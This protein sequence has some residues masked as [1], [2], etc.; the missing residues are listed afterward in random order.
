ME[1]VEAK[2]NSSIEKIVQLIFNCCYSNAVMEELPDTEMKKLADELRLYFESDYCA[3]GKFDGNFVEDRIISYKNE[4]KVQER[5]LKDVIRVSINNKENFVCQAI[6][7]SDDVLY[8]ENEELK[9]DPQYKTYENTILKGPLNNTTI[10]PIRNEQ[11]EVQGYVQ[12]INSKRK[13][14]LDDIKPFY[15]H[16]LKLIIIIKRTDVVKDTISFKKDYE[17]ITDLQSKISNVDELLKN[18]MEYFSREFSAGIISYRIPL[19]VGLERKP[20]FFLRECYISEKVS[21]Y[22]SKE[23]FFKERLVIDEKRMSSYDKLKC[24]D[25]NSIIINKTQDPDYYQR[26]SDEK[27]CFHKDN[28]IIP[29][30]RDY[31]GKNE[32]SNPFNKDPNHT[33]E[34]GN[35]CPFRF[36]KYFG[37]FRLRI[38]KNPD[39]NNHNTHDT[40]DATDWFS[41]ETKNRLIYLAKHIS[42]LF[43]SVVYK[44][45]NDSLNIF[46]EELKNTSFTKIK[47][48]DEQCIKIVRKA[49]HAKSC[50]IYRFNYSKNKLTLSASTLRDVNSIYL[51][52]DFNDTIE[53]YRDIFHIE[54]DNNLDEKLFKGKEPIYYI[55]HINNSYNSIMIVPMIRKNKSQ[56]GVML[57]AGKTIYSQKTI[58]SKTY[59]EHDKKH[60][61]FIVNTLSRIEESDSERLTFLS[62]LSHELLR[63]VTEMV[64]RNGYTIVTAN[65]NIEAYSRR[66]FLKELQKN[67]DLCMMFK[68]IID[69]AE[70]IYSLSKG[71]VQYNLEMDDLKGVI[72]Y[73]IRLFEEEASESKGLTFKTY[74]KNMPE[75]IYF[76]K[77]R[78]TQVVINLLKNAIQYSNYYEEIS[79]SY[80]F[81]EENN[82]HEIDFSDNGIAVKPEDK[83][84]I[85]ELFTRSLNAIEKRPNG[86]GI[87][88]Y[89]I[90]QIMKAHGGD[91]FVKKLSFPTIFTIQ[92]PNKQ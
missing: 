28:I 56:S 83:E 48:F 69:D 41:E 66:S 45:E 91:C 42:I 27:I 15:D 46:Q 53:Y 44:D 36:I 38:F 61:E 23:E 39:T 70:Y 55:S 72:L 71:D 47:E 13:I 32:C 80:I 17:F 14:N 90:K 76:D 87:G 18:I 12:L 29:I 5:S 60:I 89:I 10:I 62:Q 43:N 58:L 75:K 2:T 79:I 86:S 82:C 1:Q 65:R 54:S 49:L 25:I 33:C 84:R 37:V 35:N 9:K 78:M 16:I 81:D 20:L 74:L 7:S 11:K 50:A 57:L 85:F 34:N 51:N 21:N 88:L 19:L 68:Y 8:I 6:T 92:I 77:S 22:Y 63:P 73:S 30:V 31:S 52:E 3:I 40:E 67:V 4:S 24:K 64:Y 59:W 26:F